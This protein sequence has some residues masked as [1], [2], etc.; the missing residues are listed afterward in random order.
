MTFAVL[1]CTDAVGDAAQTHS[2]SARNVC[3]KKNC[4]NFLGGEFATGGH[5][6]L[7]TNIKTEF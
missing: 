3:W 1:T 5:T 4:P 7:R 2:D 6:V